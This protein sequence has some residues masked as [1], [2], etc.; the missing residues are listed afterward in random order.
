MWV[1]LALLGLL[2]RFGTKRLVL[3]F[4]IREQ[5]IGIGIY[6]GYI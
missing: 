2:R 6:Q 5:N 4:F 1:E 3:D